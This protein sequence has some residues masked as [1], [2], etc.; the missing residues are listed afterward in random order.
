MTRVPD[1]EL[2]PLS[3]KRGVKH[4][5]TDEMLDRF[6]AERCDVQY[7]YYDTAERLITVLNDM[8]VPNRVTG[9]MLGKLLRA[10]GFI[11]RQRVW[12]ETAPGEA[13][14]LTIWIGLRIKPEVI[15]KINSM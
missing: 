13:K 6:L 14:Q 10:R 12:I 3:T 7:D 2:P 8:L 4:Q 15:K 1:Y 11:K 9:V 5:L